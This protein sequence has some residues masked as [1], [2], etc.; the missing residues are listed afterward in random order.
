MGLHD[1]PYM[2]AGYEGSG[3]GVM[4]GMTIGLPKPSPAV[5]VLL[6]INLAVFIAQMFFDQS[7][8]RY[9]PGVMST[10]LGVTVGSYWQLW[11]Y[12]TCQFLHAGFMH[13]LM[14]MLGVYFLGSAMEQR[15]GT[16]RFVTFYLICGVVAGLAYVVIGAL[17][18]EMSRDMPIIGASGG[19]FGIL[20][21][22]A[23]YFP[24]FRILFLFFPVPIRFA[25]LIIF[26]GMGLMVMQA[27]ADKNVNIT[28]VMSD[29]AHLGGAVAA[30][31]WIWVIPL[32]RGRARA[33]Y[34][35]MNQGAWQRKLRRQAE[36]GAEVNRIL[37]KIRTDGL[38]SLTGKEKRTLQD[39]TKRQQKNEQDLYR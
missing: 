19:V 33:T 7:P 12:I 13:I 4:R 27:L 25:A 31:V 35:Q 6:L 34:R 16:R 1:R 24:N 8:S 38:E 23:V 30:A 22:C 9:Q 39:V 2:Q 21:A 18:P 3:G 29:V 15:W 37:D 10:Y 11:R 28:T 17:Y 32:L 36:E 20:L 26:G 14:N 5:K